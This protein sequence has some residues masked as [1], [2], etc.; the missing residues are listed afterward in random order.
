MLLSACQNDRHMLS[1][2]KP[3]EMRVRPQTQDLHYTQVPYPLVLK[4]PGLLPFSG[5]AE[6]QMH[7]ERQAPPLQ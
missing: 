4:L 3:A 2:P 1:G 6:G 7:T 5:L